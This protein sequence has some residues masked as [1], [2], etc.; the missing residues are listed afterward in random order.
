MVCTYRR[1]G[2]LS[3]KRTLFYKCTFPSWFRYLLLSACAQI[4]TMACFSTSTLAYDQTAAN[5]S[6]L[7]P[8]EEKI[9]LDCDRQ[10]YHAARGKG[11]VPMGG[12]I[13]HSFISV[14]FL[15]SAYFLTVQTYKRMRLITRVYGMSVLSDQKSKTPQ[16]CP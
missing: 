3:Y 5:S 1:L 11:A 16:K 7:S 14:H 15:I 6:S 13:N 9:L 12:A 2:Y 8:P 4:S 10:S